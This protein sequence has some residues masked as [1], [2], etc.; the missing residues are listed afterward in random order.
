MYCA[1]DTNECFNLHFP[2]YKFYCTYNLSHCPLNEANE[3]ETLMIQTLILLVKQE[4]QR[5][6][7]E[8]YQMA[9]IAVIESFTISPQYKNANV[10][11]FVLA[12][13][14]KI[15]KTNSL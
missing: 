11:N 6:A 3:H 13:P 2:N 10:A 5:D 9:E 1:G 14:F 12:V 7:W 4:T 15:K 8:F